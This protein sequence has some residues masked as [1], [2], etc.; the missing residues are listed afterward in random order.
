MNYPDTNNP[1]ADFCGCLM[2]A[3]DMMASADNPP[4]GMIPDSG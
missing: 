2:S 1:I 3:V 4:N